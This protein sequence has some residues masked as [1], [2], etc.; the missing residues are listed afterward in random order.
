M[1]KNTLL[2]I[3]EAS[4]LLGKSI[5]TLRRWDEAGVLKSIRQDEK[6]H[7]RY[8]KDDLLKF[9][10]SQKK[11]E[12]KHKVNTFI[13]DFDSTFFPDESLDE[14]L[15]LTLKNDPNRKEK[16]K[17]IE[18]ICREGMEGKIS[19]E[20]SLARRFALA[21]LH[22]DDIKKYLEKCSR[23][24]PEMK[25]CVAFLRKNS[26]RVLVVSG[27]FNRWICPLSK[28]AGVR[29][30]FI[31]TNRFLFDEAGF[32]VGFMEQNP[33]C[34]SGGKPKLI[35]QLKS[36]GTVVGTVVMIGDGASDLEVWKA[37]Q[38]DIFLGFGV[39]AC[40][41]NVQEAAPL[42]FKSIRT[43]RSFLEKIVGESNR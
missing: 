26:Q 15:K 22:K 28:E 16:S 9:L 10:N 33:L 35:S 14:V 17:Q 21:K 18:A 40:R 36:S 25:R 29:E 7:R 30:E 43:F 4:D 32:V 27:G 39:Y 13:F 20:E 12:L 37:G 24:S 19:F 8:D 34:R 41:P 42:F 38:A 23:V 1:T 11:P 31:F 2:S 6:S 5:V 3:Q